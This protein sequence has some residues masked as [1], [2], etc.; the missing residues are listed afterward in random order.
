MPQHIL[1]RARTIAKTLSSSSF[2]VKYDKYHSKY[3]VIKQHQEGLDRKEQNPLT[4]LAKGKKSIGRGALVVVHVITLRGGET[5]LPPLVQVLHSSTYSD[6]SGVT[7]QYSVCTGLNTVIIILVRTKY[8]SKTQKTRPL[9]EFF[10]CLLR[11]STTS[12]RHNSLLRYSNDYSMIRYLIS[13][14]FFT[15]EF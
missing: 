1:R 14:S 6:S 12:T 11:Y 8:P 2:F 9:F 3:T 4:G 15:I 7:I 13:S 10:R 5:L